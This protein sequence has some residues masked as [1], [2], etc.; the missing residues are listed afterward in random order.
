MEYSDNGNGSLR[1]SDYSENYGDGWVKLY[2]SFTKWEWFK[3]PKMVQ[4]F[5]YLLVSAN[6]KDK[7]WQGIEIERGQI[8]T[9]RKSLSENTG[10]SEQTIRTLLR[11]LQNSNEIT[12]KSTNK[13]TIITL[14][15]YG[16]YQQT[17][18]QPNQQLT[19]N[20]PTTNQQLTTNKNENNGKNVKNDKKVNITFDVFWSVYDYKTGNKEKIKKKWESLKDVERESIIEYLPAYKLST[21]DKQFR[22]Q[23]ATFLNNRSWEDEIVIKET[24]SD[25]FMYGESIF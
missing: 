9:G 11:K 12:Q 7:N 4:L 13:Y 25:N 10:L 14:V 2:R 1:V 5:I 22:K 21:P 23:P 24:N 15:N 8:L 3:N 17:N 16:V 19:N 6:H 18:Q 20:Q